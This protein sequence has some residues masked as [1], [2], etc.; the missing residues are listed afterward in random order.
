MIRNKGS[1]AMK[2]FYW[3]F[4]SNKIEQ[5]KKTIIQSSWVF[6]SSERGRRRCREGWTAGGSLLGVV[7]GVGPGAGVVVLVPGGPSLITPVEG[8]VRTG[9]VVPAR[10]VPGVVCGK[11]DVIF[12]EDIKLI[13]KAVNF[14]SYLAC[15]KAWNMPGLVSKILRLNMPRLIC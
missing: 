3:F 8:V 6:R 13:Q 12:T 14:C 7:G 4:S 2:T 11:T 1:L 5:F 9:V 10:R 15:F